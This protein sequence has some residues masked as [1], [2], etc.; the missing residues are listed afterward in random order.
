V[1]LLNPVPFHQLGR[2]TRQVA[3]RV[4]NQVGAA[5]FGDRASRNGMLP[6]DAIA[7][8]FAVEP[9]NLYQFEQWRRPLEEL[10]RTRP[11]FV[12]VDRPDTGELV[13]ESTTL[14]V[15]LAR[16]SAALEN[17]VAERG[18]RVVLYVNQVEANFRMLRFAGPV[19]IQLGHGESDKISSASNQHKAYDLTFVG[20]P[21]GRDR[22]GRA[23]RGY[24]A[25]QRTV[26]TGRPQLDYT[27]PSADYPGASDGP[28]SASERW[29]F[30]APTW[31]GDRPSISYGSLASHGVALVTA[32]LAE[33]S[34][35]VLYRPHP[36]TGMFSPAHSDADAA[37]RRML[38]GPRHLVDT[39]SYGWQWGFA[40]A[41]ITDISAVAYDWL[42]TGKPLA[43]T[44]PGPG[45]YVPPSPLLDGLGLMPAAEAGQVLSRLDADASPLA[46]TEYYFGDTAD[47][48]S[49]ARFQAAIES[50]YAVA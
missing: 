17:I 15:T 7:L 16:G 18:V 27:Y 28:R 37:I 14:P 26:L 32:L 5:G 43:I 42:A 10:A 48:A 40:D 13:L 9:D 6:N 30:Y 38:T 35:R 22:L 29:I 46:L 19:H 50:A 36:R 34:V 3:A 23:L 39:G 20:G 33:P 12:I 11:V 21:A 1:R 2:L 24:D 47:R 44:A 25:E 4:R 45:A 31:E 49:T 8:F 41:C